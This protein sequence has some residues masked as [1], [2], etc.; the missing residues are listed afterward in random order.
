M[1]E[2]WAVRT[3]VFDLDDTLYPERDFVVSGFRAVGTWLEQYRKIQDFAAHA[4][5][6]FRHGRRDRIFNEALQSMKVPHDDA[7]VSRLVEVYQQHKPEIILP[8]ESGAVLDWC[9]GRFNLALI[10]DGYREV[11]ESKIV[12]LGLAARIPCLVV[13]DALGREFW[14]P[15]PVPYRKVMERFGG[16]AAEYVYV[17]DNPAK[18]F[19]G[20]RQLGW[21]TIRIKRPGGEHAEVVAEAGYDADISISCL[22]ALE[23]VLIHEA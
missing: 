2:T 3:V 17:A 7:L 6:L 5:E 1:V 23:R 12:A 8:P 16:Q 19:I 9:A 15:S 4:E 22:C 20:A 13:T 11:Q 21:R 10:T 14:K 18:D